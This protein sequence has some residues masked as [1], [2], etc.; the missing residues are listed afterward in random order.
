MATVPDITDE[1]RG[2]T[3]L[4]FDDPA[5]QTVYDGRKW[6]VEVEVYV[7]K[8]ATEEQLSE[9]IEFTLGG[10]SIADDHPLTECDLG[11]VSVI[12]V[13]RTACHC[14]TDWDA[15]TEDGRRS[16]RGRIVRQAAA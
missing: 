1:Q 15:K 8:D 4:R 9:L 6:T 7:K 3:Q 5:P 13:R 10:G 12:D 11:K 2:N 14:F 16:G